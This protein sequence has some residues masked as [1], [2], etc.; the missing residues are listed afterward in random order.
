MH[1]IVVGAGV[2]GV[3]T[4]WYLANEGH[5]VT[6]IERASGPA[7]QTSF[8]NAGGVCPSFAGPWAAPGMPLKALRWMFQPSAPLLLRPKFDV[9]Q[10][11]WLWQFMRNCTDQRFAENKA[12]MQAMAHYSLRC[13]QDLRAETGIDYDHGDKGVLQVFATADELAGGER[14]AAVLAKLNIPHRLVGASEAQRIEPALTHS[15]A[16]IVGGLHLPEDETGDSY[17]FTQRLAH[18]A[19]ERGVRFIYDTQVNGLVLEKQGQGQ[20]KG[21]QTVDGPEYADACVL[22]CGPY[23]APLLARAKLHLPVYPVKGYSMTWQVT[24]D[25]RAPQSSLMDEHSKVMITRLGDRI[26]AAGMAEVTGYDTRLRAPALQ[27][28][29]ARTAA[30]FPGAAQYDKGQAWCGFRPM[31][32]DGPAMV[33]PTRIAGLYLNA[34]H[35]SNGWTQACGTSRSL[36]DL[37]SGKLPEVPLTTITV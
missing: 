11:R 25:S 7:L 30:L 12:R 21:V 19:R 27:S 23:V 10:W 3:T 35:G 34:G 9:A 24:D 29:S 8:G 37:I 15:N 26:R 1:I 33:G 6:V 2:V 31:T 36:A 14:A 32:P 17:L 13:L 16:T 28:L 18:L 4:A 20:L 5:Q 22:A